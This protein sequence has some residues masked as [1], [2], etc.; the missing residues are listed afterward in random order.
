LSAVSIATSV[1]DGWGLDDGAT[2]DGLEDEDLRR[3]VLEEPLYFF[4]VAATTKRGGEGFDPVVEGDR[5]GWSWASAC[6][7]GRSCRRTISSSCDS[8]STPRGIV[9]DVMWQSQL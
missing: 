8:R 7:I 9:S 4:L 5:E 1:S 3:D 2:G 6:A